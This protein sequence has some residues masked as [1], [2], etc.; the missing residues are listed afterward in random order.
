MVGALCILNAHRLLSG[1]RDNLIKV[2]TVSKED[3][4][5]I[6]KITEHIAT[7][8][9]I[10]PLSRGRFASCSDD[11]SIKIWKDDKTYDYIF[12][13]KENTRRSIIQLRGKEVLV[14]CGDEFFTG[15]TFWNL[16]NYTQQHR[17]SGYGVLLPNHMIELANGNI[18]IS[19]NV[20]PYPVIIIDG[21][22]YQVLTIIKLKECIPYHSSLCLFN[23][24]SFLYV[25]KGTFLQ[26][27]SEDCTILF[28]SKGGNFVGRYG[29]IVPIE[30]GKY[31]AIDNNKCISIIKLSDT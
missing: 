12:T 14:T 21:S 3:L 26:I 10:I 30:G 9:R 29:G 6:K 1:S 4:K 7:V 2:W 20:K 19:S 22:S 11:S 18:A 13:L 5:L 28:Q 8:W 17:I 31:F 25:Y 24:H 15:V 23:D 27:S 16:N